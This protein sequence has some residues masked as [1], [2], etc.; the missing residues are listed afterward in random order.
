M[1]RI[2]S[3]SNLHRAKNAKK[4]EFYT[5]LADIENELK[6]YKEHFKDKV[7]YCNC[8]DPYESNF[9]KYFVL[10]F[11]HLGLKKL[12]TTCYDGSSI[13]RKDCLPLIFEDEP[14][15][16]ESKTAH[17]V[18]INEVKDFNHD[19]KI[20]QE[21]IKYLLE[22]DRNAS[23]LLNEHGDFRS[24]EAIEL[25]KQAD[26]VV[27]N[28]PF[29]L[30]REYVAQLI[31][32]DKKFLIIGNKNAVTYKELFPLIAENKLWLGVTPMSFDIFFNV[33]KDYQEYL[34]QSK[35]EGS[36]YRIIDG[37]VKA[38]ATAV[39]FTNLDHKKR[40]EELILYKKYTPE[41]YPKYDNYDAINV[42]KVKEIPCDYDGV[43]GVP[44]TFLD[45]FN[46][47]QFEIVGCSYDYGRPKEFPK[48]TNM[49]PTITRER[50]TKCLQASLH[51]TPLIS[52]GLMN[53]PK[54][55]KVL[56]KSRYARVLI[57]VKLNG[58]V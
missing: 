25:L 7:I 45:K 28:P 41:E 1:A 26:I 21:D 35:K 32:Y 20:D 39:W 17:K 49:N 23:A 2:S 53:N 38:R 52:W 18:E 27:T 13:A 55:T 36:A 14:I 6:H 58:N 48:D 56:G 31:E 29:S 34:T 22:H 47:E 19:G 30:F 12:I 3:N 15:E 40:H 4:D 8:D 57:R 33:P 16:R 50:E 10:N 46:P 5:Q 42:D 44:I 54:D 37:E 51:Q 24:K 9:F 11:N 43:M